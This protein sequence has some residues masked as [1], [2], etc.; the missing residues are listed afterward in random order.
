MTFA[1]NLKGWCNTDTGPY[2]RPFTPNSEWESATVLIVGTN[3]ATPLRDEFES[4]DQ[5]WQGLTESPEIFNERYTTAHQ[6]GT[7]KSTSNANQLLKL[8]EPL[9][10]LVTNVVWFPVSSKKEI[11]K[12]EWEFGQTA[13]TELI[14]HVRPKVVFCH[15]ADAEAFGKSLDPAVDRYLPPK[16]Q[17]N[18]PWISP[19]VLA[20]HHFSGQ[21]LRR[22]AEF[23]PQR[24]FPVFAKAIHGHGRT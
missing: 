12:S 24:D 6:G 18:S 10:V 2:R 7:S 9:N 22:G 14:R 20:Y 3:P 5:Y 16:D 23:K 8:L 21:G 15:G 4:F 17:V 19:L 11:P 13:L 1:E